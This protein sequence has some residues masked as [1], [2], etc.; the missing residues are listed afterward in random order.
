MR[1][2][3]LPFL[4]PAL[5][6]WRSLPYRNVLWNRLE[7]FLGVAKPLSQ[8][9]VLQLELTNSCNLSCKTCGHSWWNKEENR[10]R[11]MPSE[12]LE[13]V[14]DFL[15]KTSEIQLGGYGEPTLHPRLPE[16]VETLLNWAP[17]LH[18]NMISNLTRVDRVLPILPRLHRLSISMDGS[19]PVYEDRRGY[20]FQKFSKNLGQVM[21]TN[22]ETSVE[23]NLVW[24]RM[25]HLNLE[26][27]IRFLEKFPAI[28]HLHLLPEKMYGQSRA[29]ESIFRPEILHTL[30]Q[31]L[32]V[33]RRSTDLRIHAP[34]LFAWPLE[35]SQPWDTL[36]VLS[37]G[38]VMACCSA[39]FRG[40]E[41]RFS[42]GY[43]Q[44][45][46]LKSLW[47]SEEIQK[48]R[49]A[50]AKRGEYPL[51]CQDC[52]FRYPSEEFLSRWPQVP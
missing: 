10:P 28:R 44:K 43:I 38:E 17:H 50:R 7:R 26:E 1:I 11:M 52:A 30:L 39:I 16:F 22:P 29:R 37:D 19:G 34:N 49:R 23:I 42:L 20:S 27:T 32:K 3:V 9:I 4:K 46:D 31:D 6:A 24:N 35:C 21:A 8:P 36:F 48:F 15:P 14:R 25:T 33:L 5:E 12:A 2:P 41:H 40:H 13:S 45:Q 47:Y 18:L 51:P